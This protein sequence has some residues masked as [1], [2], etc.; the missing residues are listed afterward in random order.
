M[1]SSV[2]SGVSIRSGMVARGVRRKTRRLS[3]MTEGW[4]ATSKNVR[5]VGDRRAPRGSP[6]PATQSRTAPSG[7][8][9]TSCSGPK[10]RPH[11]PRSISSSSFLG[12]DSGVPH[13]VAAL[14]HRLDQRGG[15]LVG[16]R[17][18]VDHQ[19]YR[20]AMGGRRVGENRLGFGAVDDLVLGE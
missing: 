10:M 16:R 3:I 11:S 6:Q 7:W 19:R 12:A 17:A 2:S 1:M 13:R 20:A 15:F 4:A 14:E 9:S 8:W 18:A 5:G